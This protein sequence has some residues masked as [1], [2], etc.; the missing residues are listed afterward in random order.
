MKSIDNFI[1]MIY[2]NNDVLIYQEKSETISTEY[3]VFLK[4]LRKHLSF[5]HVST[6][7]EKN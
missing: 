4:F 7:L 6:I 5:I 1:L 2:I 3:Y